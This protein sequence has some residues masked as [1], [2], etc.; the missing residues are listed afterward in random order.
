MENSSGFRSQSTIECCRNCV[1]PKRHPGCHGHC[2]E[3]IKEKTEYEGRKAAYY[4]DSSVKNGLTAQRS[5]AV[6]TALRRR[7]KINFVGNRR[8]G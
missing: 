4:G 6:N 2:S 5:N 1:A 8:M 7:R 3:Y